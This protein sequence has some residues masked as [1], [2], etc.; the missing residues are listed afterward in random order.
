MLGFA[1]LTFA[2]F[3]ALFTAAAVLP[4]QMREPAKAA[5][6]SVTPE[7]PSRRSFGGDREAVGVE[8]SWTA[9]F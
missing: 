1:K 9:N 5:T 3:S 8:R 6:R 7:A 2:G 4:V